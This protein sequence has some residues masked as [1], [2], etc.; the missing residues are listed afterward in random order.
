VNLERAPRVATDDCPVPSHQARSDLQVVA[1]ASGA[2]LDGVDLSVGRALLPPRFVSQ[3]QIEQRRN[4]HHLSNLARALNQLCED[5]LAEERVGGEVQRGRRRARG[6]RARGDRAR[7]PLAGRRSRRCRRR[8][9]GGRRRCRR[10][11]SRHERERHLHG[12]ADADFG[13]AIARHAHDEH[14][15]GVR[16]GRGQQRAQ[17]QD[18]G[19]GVARCADELELHV[20]DG[21]EDARVQR[22]PVISVRVDAGQQRR[23]QPGGDREQVGCAD[24]RRA[25][26][27]GAGNAERLKRCGAVSREPLEEVAQRLAGAAHVEQDVAEPRGSGASGA[28][29][30]GVRRICEDDRPGVAAHARE[31]LAQF[32]SHRSDVRCARI[33][34][35]QMCEKFM[36]RHELAMAQ[37]VRSERVGD[38]VL[39]RKR[40]GAQTCGVRHDLVGDA[41]CCALQRSRDLALL[42][43]Q[44]LSQAIATHKDFL[45][46]LSFGKI[47]FGT[48]CEKIPL[49]LSFWYFPFGTFCEKKGK[50][51]FL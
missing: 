31:R 48:F 13:E 6:A 9:D 46:V 47:P 45:L 12:R 14:G 5:E 51:Y 24:R 7:L 15:R 23:A 8:D 26:E 41:L 39:R 10:S 25:L 2:F 50:T 34:P 32:L 16:A 33:A 43:E 28:G 17:L 42:I 1:V 29:D 18:T 30:A 22:E 40:V 37:T 3:R 4:G 11:W 19:A 44:L 49:V 38:V 36:E 27:V 35:P 21:A 20:V